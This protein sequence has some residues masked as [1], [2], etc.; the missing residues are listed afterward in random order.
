[1][2][3]SKLISTKEFNTM[4]TYKP[5]TESKTQKQIIKKKLLAFVVSAYG[6]AYY[7]LKEGTKKAI[8][9]MCWFATERGFVYA[10]DSYLAERYHISDRTIR[11]VAKV[12]REKGLILTVYR[13]STKHNGRGCPIHIFVNH[14]HFNHWVDFLQIDNFQADFQAEKS[15]SLCGS[16]KEDEKKDS[17]FNLT[18]KHKNINKRKSCDDLDYHFT[19]SNVPDTFIK[20]VKPFFSKAKDIYYF[21]GRVLLAHNQS[22][23]SYPVED[24]I[25]V[26]IQAFKESVFAYRHN[27]IKKEFAG[28]FFGTFRKMLAAEVRRR[29]ISQKEVNPVFCYDFIG[30]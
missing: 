2:I 10:G 30:A 23:L 24:Y 22:N 5:Y 11:N 15:E 20:T 26:A 19:P 1:M 8:D 17:T 14:P 3:V 9:M 12:F 29:A 4:Q 28:Y 21:W 18:L 13:S 6:D 25:N 16:K 7:R 27:R